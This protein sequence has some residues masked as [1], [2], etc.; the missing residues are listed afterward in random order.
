MKLTRIT[1]LAA[2]SMALVLV[3]SACSSSATT[4]P[5]AAAVLSA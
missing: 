2:G 4:A 3:A 1:G 5:S